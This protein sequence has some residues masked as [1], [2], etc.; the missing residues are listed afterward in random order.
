MMRRW[1]AGDTVL[2]HRTPLVRFQKDHPDLA[3]EMSSLESSP[4]L[5]SDGTKCFLRSAQRDQQQ[6][7]GG[8]QTSLVGSH[9]GGDHRC[10]WRCWRIPTSSGSW[11]DRSHSGRGLLPVRT[12][13]ADWGW[14]MW[15]GRCGPVCWMT[16]RCCWGLGTPRMHC[17]LWLQSGCAAEKGTAGGQDLSSSPQLSLSTCC[18]PVE[19]PKKYKSWYFRWYFSKHCSFPK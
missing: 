4:H 2:N 11:K 9:T 17:W 7:V 8:S 19:V 14:W 1:W 5:D 6:R 18:S 16:G 13:S 3:G 10:V 15:M 12:P